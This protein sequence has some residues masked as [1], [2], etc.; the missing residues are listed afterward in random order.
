[1]ASRMEAQQRK[2][3]VKEMR[4]S[5]DIEAVATGEYWYGTKALSLGLVDRLVT[6]DDY[7]L[8]GAERA[9]VLEVSCERRRSPRERILSLASALMNWV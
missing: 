4:P 5:L 3:F 2:D 7:L 8:E 1:M 9:R 6:S